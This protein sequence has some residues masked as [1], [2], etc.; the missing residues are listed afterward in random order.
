MVVSTPRIVRGDPASPVVLHVPHAGRLVPVDAR[1]RM[2]L[3]DA[4]LAA[5]ID[6]LT[7]HDTDVLALAAADRATVRPWVIVNPLSRFVV[8]VERF[9]DEREEMRAVGMGAVYT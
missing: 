3:D 4:A 5:E 6:V 9:P 2:L 8:D 1:R 7:D